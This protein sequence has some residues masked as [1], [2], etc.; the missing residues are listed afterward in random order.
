MTP[1][2]PHRSTHSNIF[3]RECHLH[4][5]DMSSAGFPLAFR[6]IL[7]GH[8]SRKPHTILYSY[9]LLIHRPQS[10]TWAR[11]L[12]GRLYTFLGNNHSQTLDCCL[13]IICVVSSFRHREP[14]WHFYLQH[15]LTSQ[16]VFHVNNGDVMAI[17]II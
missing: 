1:R 3:H 12:C 9:V 2:D 13:I 6:T 7:W 11:V 17:S 16:C 5:L 15:W 8:Y 10:Q 4:H 14:L